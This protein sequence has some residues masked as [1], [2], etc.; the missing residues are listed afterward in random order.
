M[1]V[2]SGRYR[3]LKLNSL[4]TNDTRPT[5]AKVKEAIFNMLM[6]K[7]SD[8]VCLDLFAGSGA[9]GIEALSLHAKWVDFNDANYKAVKVI[10]E[11][12]IKIKNDDYQLTNLD[13]LTFLNN[14]NKTY[15]LIF[16]DP[17]YH[18]NLLEKV[19]K[20][21]LEKNLVNEDG[22]I[23]CEMSSE[24]NINIEALSDLEIYKEKKYGLTKVVILRRI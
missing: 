13:Y 10:K 12:L 16:L 23:V 19:I 14:T 6:N 15:D 17:P 21:I 8:T 18:L 5:L 2:A 11:N 4:D 22:L 7:V 9:L 1:R 20:L 24:S 3:S